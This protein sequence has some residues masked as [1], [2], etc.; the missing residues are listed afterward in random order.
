MNNSYKTAIVR[1]RPSLP[2][3]ILINDNKINKDDKI[4][5][6]GCGRGTDYTWLQLNNYNANGYDPYWNPTKNLLDKKYDIVL[7]SYVLNVVN[8]NKRRAVINKLKGLINKSG[9][10]YITVRRDIKK[11]YTTKY[12][13]HQYLVYLPYKIIKETSAYCIYEINKNN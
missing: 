2:L 7:C 6:F 8:I 5:D 3:R 10:I 4:L 9:K 1:K 13:V 11:D 12:G